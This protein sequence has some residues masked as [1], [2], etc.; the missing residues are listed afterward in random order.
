MDW[1]ILFN[2]LPIMGSVVLLLLGWWA[3][4]IW[5]NLSKLRENVENVKIDLSKNYLS[6]IDIDN[7]FTK[8]DL[9]FDKIYV[10]LDSLTV[11]LNAV[12]IELNKK[13]DRP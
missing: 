11:T 6:K 7:I 9:Q 3:R 8:V 5:G 1:Q 12:L 13:Q 4:E 10:K 2:L